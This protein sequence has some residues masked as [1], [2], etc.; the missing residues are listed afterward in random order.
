MGH[1]P[2]FL[3]WVMVY[4][5]ITIGNS[6]ED[7]L[8]VADRSLFLLDYIRSEKVQEKLKRKGPLPPILP[9]KFRLDPM[10]EH[11]ETVAIYIES[12][13]G[14]AEPSAA[15]LERNLVIAGFSHN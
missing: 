11:T 6:F 4:Y 9:E 13:E 3:V 10:E 7:C 8:N 2:S 15:V 14:H 5:I 1:L 12:S